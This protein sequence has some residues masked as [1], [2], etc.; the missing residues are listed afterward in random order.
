M[1]PMNRKVVA[2]AV[3]TLCLCAISLIVGFDVKSGSWRTVPFQPVSQSNV[4]PLR[5][6]YVIN[7]RFSVM[8]SRQLDILLQETKTVVKDHF[9]VDLQFS[10]LS[11]LGL[12]ELFMD[13]PLV[14]QEWAL[15][16][17]YDFKSGAGE[18]KA[19]DIFL[20]KY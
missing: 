6:A 15:E 19:I 12:D 7:P 14:A 18:Q 17:V 8:S 13:I 11:R 20:E 1:F 4:I 3:L 16:R 5:V 2:V 10:S 9:K